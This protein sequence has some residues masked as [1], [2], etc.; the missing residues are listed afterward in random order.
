MGVKLNST[1]TN[2]FIALLVM[3]SA[4]TYAE[5]IN[6]E[7]LRHIASK[8]LASQIEQASFYCTKKDEKYQFTF[9]EARREFE[10]NNKSFAVANGRVP[11]NFKLKNTELDDLVNNVN[12]IFM[13]AAE[14]YP[15]ET[16]CNNYAY[17]LRTLSFDDFLSLSKMKYNALKEKAKKL[18]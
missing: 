16:F 11:N 3:Q 7:T 1:V 9:L 12:A 8:M 13:Q 14:K 10:K 2:M 17:K 4:V 6:D 15:F 18:P 5:E